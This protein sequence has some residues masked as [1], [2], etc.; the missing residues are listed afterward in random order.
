M[1]SKG[2]DSS[3]GEQVVQDI[4]ETHDL[5]NAKIIDHVAEVKLCRKF[6]FRILPILAI[7]YLFNALDK[8]NLGNAKTDG[9]DKNIGLVGNQ[10]NIILSVFYVPYV[11]T[12]FPVALIGK[13]FG[14]SIV[15]PI[16]M[17]IFGSM[18]LLSAAVQN[19]GGMM[20][21]RWILGMAEAGF[22]PLVI[23][24]VSLQALPLTS[25]YDVLSTVGTCSATGYFLRS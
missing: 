5:H 24:Y 20:T 18:C 21:V 3:V 15:L 19:F 12:A 17:F 8:G 16:L 23:Y 14:P 9:F 6:D 13:K 11:L 4:A 25:A 22:F 7:M 1:I 10:Y 2:K